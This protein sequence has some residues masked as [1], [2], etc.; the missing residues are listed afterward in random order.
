MKNKSEFRF[1]ACCLFT[2]AVLLAGCSKDN[3]SADL[4]DPDITAVQPVSETTAADDI[5]GLAEAENAALVHAGVDE[6]EADFTKTEL[7][8]DNG[9][10]EYEIEFTANGYKYEYDINANNGSVLKF[11]KKAIAADSEEN[12]IY[13]EP[14]AETGSAAKPAEASQPAATTAPKPAETQKS[15]TIIASATAVKQST[16]TAKEAKTAALNHAGLSA[17]E[18]TFTKTELDYD[19]GIAEYEIEFNTAADEYEYEINAATGAVIK[20][21][22]EALKLPAMNN[23][24]GTITAEEAKTAA[25]NHAGLSASEV[26]FTKTKLDYD[27]GRAEYEIEFNTAADKYEYD[28]NA[29]TGTVIKYS[30]EAL[31]NT[32]QNGSTITADDAKNAAL[33]YAGLN[34]SDVRFTKA[35]LDYDDGRA[36]Y[37][38]E[39]YSG[40]KEYEFKIDAYSGEIIEVDID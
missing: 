7:D 13:V 22:K 6:S 30:K 27:D 37:E 17:S 23:T 38:I 2:A 39:F 10:A 14:P 40:R 12:I 11:S 26:T 36:E 34:A 1:A 21:S 20:Y 8:Y 16:I 35:E 5:I 19:D 3:P 24:N 33:K 32:S 28:I 4:P 29:A 9:K 25:L 31:K 15:T 18:V